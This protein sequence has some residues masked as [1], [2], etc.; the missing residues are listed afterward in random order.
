M[1]TAFLM[2]GAPE[3]VSDAICSQQD[4]EAI[5]HCDIVAALGNALNRMAELGSRLE[6]ATDRAS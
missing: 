4:P 6:A 3:D 1:N 5:P 2:Y